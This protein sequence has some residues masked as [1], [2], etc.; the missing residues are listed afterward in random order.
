MVVEHVE[1]ERRHQCVTQAV[2]LPEES[3][4]AAR[5][6]VVPGAPLVDV[7]RNLARRVVLVENLDVLRDEPVDPQ[8]LRQRRD[9]FRLGESE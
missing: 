4:F 5:L 1:I 2:L 6:R 3:R 9:P 7:E 8:G